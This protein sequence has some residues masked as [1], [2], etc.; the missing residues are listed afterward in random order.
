L[1][2][3]AGN[4][5]LYGGGGNDT[6]IGGTGNDL[7]IGGA[8]NDIFVFQTANDGNDKIGDFAI[9]QDVVNLQGLYHDLG[10]SDYNQAV[11]EGYLQVIQLGAHTAIQ[12]DASGGGDSFTTLVTLSNV[13]T[14]SFLSNGGIV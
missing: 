9:G 14:E 2:G 4:D 3:D 11:S 5:Q 10:I 1:H 7:L 6:L 8:G 13:N 12:V